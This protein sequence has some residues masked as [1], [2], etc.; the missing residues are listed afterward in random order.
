MCQQ[1]V[2]SRDSFISHYCLATRCEAPSA[3]TKRFVQ[4]PPV[5]YLWQVYDTVWFDLHVVGIEGRLEDIGR[6]FREGLC[7]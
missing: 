2:L 4:Y 1:S 6:L 5:L 3:G 7:R